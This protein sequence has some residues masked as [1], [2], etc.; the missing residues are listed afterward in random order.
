MSHRTLCAALIAVSLP[1]GTHVA[2][3]YALDSVARATMLESR[4]FQPEL[5]PSDRGKSIAWAQIV[6]APIR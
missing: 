4:L 1:A 6:S 2:V 5:R 3:H